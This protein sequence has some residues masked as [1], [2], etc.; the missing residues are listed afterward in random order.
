MSKETEKELV[1]TM[2][3]GPKSPW[4]TN[5]ETNLHIK[6]GARLMA[7]NQRNIYRLLIQTTNTQN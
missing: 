4:T 1:K 6:E 2:N 7:L 3:K 5:D